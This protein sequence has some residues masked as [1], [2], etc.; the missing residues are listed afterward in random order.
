[1]DA[2]KR[3]RPDCWNK[4]IP[5]KY[6]YWYMSYQNINKSDCYNFNDNILNYS[7]ISN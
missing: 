4:Y 2:L 1:M 3:A 5:S 6:I 7:L